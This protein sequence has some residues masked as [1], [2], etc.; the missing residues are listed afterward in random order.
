MPQHEPF[1]TI[2]EAANI[3]GVSKTTIRNAV[4]RGQLAAVRGG[5]M[6]DRTIGVTQMS[7]Q[8]I[9]DYRR[10]RHAGEITDKDGYDTRDLRPASRQAAN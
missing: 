9:I 4:A 1:Y 7:V 6:G 2:E 10:K 5:I 8:G 3:L